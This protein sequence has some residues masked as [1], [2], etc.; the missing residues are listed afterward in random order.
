[1]PSDRF[2]YDQFNRESR[3]YD[4]DIAWRQSESKIEEARHLADKAQ[5]HREINRIKEPKRLPPTKSGGPWWTG[6]MGWY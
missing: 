1:M 4:P 2:N 6:A 5:R 3:G